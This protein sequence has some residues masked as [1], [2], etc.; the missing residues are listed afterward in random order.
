MDRLTDTTSYR[1]SEVHLKTNLNEEFGS[2]S[3]FFLN[4]G[5]GGVPFLPGYVFF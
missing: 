4:Y 1:D 3:F 2:F 5:C